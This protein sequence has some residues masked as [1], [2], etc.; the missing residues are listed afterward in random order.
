MIGINYE[1]LEFQ[2]KLSFELLQTCQNYINC[3]CWNNT[4]NMYNHISASC[5]L[6]SYKVV[7]KR[8]IPVSKFT[9]HLFVVA[10]YISIMSISTLCTFCYHLSGTHLLFIMVLSFLYMIKPTI[11]GV[12]WLVSYTRLYYVIPCT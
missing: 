3:H 12:P 9:I 11:L 10:F 2:L 1:Y 7:C 5:L 6:K 8:V 4:C